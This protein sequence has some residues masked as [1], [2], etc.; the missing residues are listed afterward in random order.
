M[1]LY[2]DIVRKQ[3]RYKVYTELLRRVKNLD[4]IF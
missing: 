3:N 2:V 4:H 1:C